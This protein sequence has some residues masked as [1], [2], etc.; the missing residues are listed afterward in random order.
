MPFR[1]KFFLFILSLV[2]LFS[3]VSTAIAQNTVNIPAVEDII[4]DEAT[5]SADATGSALQNKEEIEKIKKE[6]I[7]KPEEPEEKGEIFTLFN[8]RPADELKV[9]NFMAFFVQRSVATGV[10]ANTIVLI[11]LLPFL[12]TFFAFARVVL[13]FTIME[14]LVTI[15]LSIAFI[16][17]GITIGTILLLT[18]LIASFFSR[19]LLKRLKIMQLPKMAMSILIVSAFVFIALSLTAYLDV[20]KVTQI[21]IFP[22]LVYILISDKIVALQLQSNYFETIRIT[23]ITVTIAFLGYLFLS[24]KYVQDLILIYPELILILIPLNIALGRYFGLR[25]T[26]YIRFSS[27]LKN[28]N[29]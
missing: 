7:T 10:P 6:D 20:I 28:G 24:W 3:F 11:L 21:S 26:E 4:I 16:A 19:I 14:M 18:I 27:L 13:G 12:A 25:L 17:T 23:L 15:I 5:D 1:S 22:I 2:F 29:K 9:T 8:A